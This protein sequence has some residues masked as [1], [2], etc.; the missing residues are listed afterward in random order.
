MRVGLFLGVEQVVNAPSTPLVLSPAVVSLQ[1]VHHLET[2][3]AKRT[4]KQALNNK[5]TK[6]K[7][8][9]NAIADLAIGQGDAGRGMNGKEGEG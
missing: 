4:T 5:Q 7:T 3:S 6:K 1:E 8:Q 9:Q 2:I